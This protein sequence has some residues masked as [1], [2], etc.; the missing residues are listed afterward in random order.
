MGCSEWQMFHNPDAVDAAAVALVCSS[1]LL[2]KLTA[3][4]CVA[5][6]GRLRCHT[7][8]LRGACVLECVC[9]VNV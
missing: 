3:L 4:Y 1:A 2:Q 9:A 7:R 5:H 8:G 6:I